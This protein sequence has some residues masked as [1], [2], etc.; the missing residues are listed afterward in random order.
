ME[1]GR[2]DVAG[3]GGEQYCAGAGGVGRQRVCGGDFFKAGGNP[4][5]YI[6]K[7]DGS[8]W[9][10]LGSGMNDLV[11]A[12]AVSGSDLFAGGNF[13]MAGGKVAPYIARASLP[14]LPTLSIRRSDT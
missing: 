5:N 1:R 2:L 6:A 14:T 8:S 3:R 10:A 4:A 9:T 13:T 12:I 7:W 11:Y